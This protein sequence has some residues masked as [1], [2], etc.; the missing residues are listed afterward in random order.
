MEEQE[1]NRIKVR[2]SRSEV[3]RT[4]TKMENRGGR[5]K[6]NGSLSAVN[7]SPEFFWANVSVISVPSVANVFLLMYFGCGYAALCSL[8]FNFDNTEGK[9]K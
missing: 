2:G 7:L 1:K 6:A 4:G 3:G 9:E 8:W 5:L